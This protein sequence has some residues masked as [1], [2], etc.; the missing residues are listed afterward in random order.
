MAT[1]VHGRFFPSRTLSGADH[2]CISLFRGD[3]L[4][5]LKFEAYC[6]SM[7]L[8]VVFSVHMS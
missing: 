4:H 6:R 1:F 2:E 3:T 8:G 7:L 5:S